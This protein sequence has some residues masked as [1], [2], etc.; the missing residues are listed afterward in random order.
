[1]PL[2]ISNCPMK[3]TLLFFLL[4]GTFF[5]TLA[6]VGSDKRLVAM[7]DTIYKDD[8]DVRLKFESALRKLGSGSE[9]V[10][11][12]GEE[13]RRNDSINV[14]KVAKILDR[15]GWPNPDIAGKKGSTTVF[16][17]IQHADVDVQVKY[18]PLVREA[19]KNKKLA[20]SSFAMLEDRVALRQGKKQIY[21]S[22]IETAEDDSFIVAPLEDPDNVDKRR[23]KIGLEPM[24]EYVKD[25]NIIW[26]V[27]EYK[28]ASAG[29]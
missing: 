10:M 21:G 11:M 17:V 3:R 4:N 28:K 9:E 5:G 22:Q 29:K 7:L 25:W 8:Q 15:Y 19:V 20:A 2:S 23:A 26:N 1:M 18:L 27:E 13:M 14:I 24:A 12:L 16:F 6:Q